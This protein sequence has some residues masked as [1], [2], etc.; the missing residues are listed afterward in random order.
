MIYSVMN[1]IKVYVGQSLN[2]PYNCTSQKEQLVTIIIGSRVHAN[3]R[4][5]NHLEAKRT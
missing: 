4:H 1:K 2:C 3:D 5:M